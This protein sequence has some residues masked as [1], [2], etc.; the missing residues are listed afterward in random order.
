[1]GKA[2]DLRDK[3][4]G[5]LTALH[6][7]EERKNAMRVWKCAC[8]CGK[9]VKIPTSWLTSGNTTS[10]GCY[11]LD[12]RRKRGVGEAGLFR[13]F[14][15]YLKEAQ[16][17]G[18]SFELSLEAFAALTKETCFYCGAEPSR[19]MNLHDSP[20]SAYTYNG[21]D[22][23]NNSKGYVPGNCVACCFHCNVAKRDRSIK[24][25]DLWVRALWKRLKER[26]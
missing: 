15:R 13:L 7:L 24:D 22:R 20:Y 6:L 19:V 21:V 12:V 9:Q 16:A 8:D 4:F 17:R 1:M 26:S 23:M 5:R 11:A 3:K 25:F 14:R 18:L 10:C 2:L